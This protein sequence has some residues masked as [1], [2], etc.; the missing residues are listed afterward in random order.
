VLKTIDPS[1]HVAALAAPHDAEALERLM[2]ARPE[3]E[4]TLLSRAVVGIWPPY[5][6]GESA[7]TLIKAAGDDEVKVTVTQRGA[8]EVH[9]DRIERAPT[10]KMRVAD[11]VAIYASKL[12]FN[13]TF[14]SR[15]APLWSMPSLLS[16]VTQLPWM[17]RLRLADVT[18]WMGDGH[19]HNTLH[20]DPHDNALCQLH[21]TKHL[22][23]YPPA[24][25]DLLYYAP[26]RNSFAEY[27]PGKG[28]HKRQQTPVISDNTAQINI[29][30]VDYEAFPKFR[31]AQ[32]LQRYARL[33]RG[34]CFYLPRTWHHVVFS[35][36]GAESGFNLAVNLWFDR[37][38]TLNGKQ[39]SRSAVAQ[40]VPRPQLTLNEV[41]AALARA[42]P[43][44]GAGPGGTVVRGKDEL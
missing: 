43:A 15:Q 40:N 14:F 20:N 29:A 37:E 2:R 44:W 12:E 7:A 31:D 8:F 34:D 5:F 35:E 28:E 16:T 23:L 32:K 22:L 6:W 39:P 3:P 13:T 11:L 33:E 24:A 18:M 25:K 36:A 19:F 27:A 17:E 41:H 10:S 26:R 21:G 42:N 38:A 1:S 30:K 4:P 9:A